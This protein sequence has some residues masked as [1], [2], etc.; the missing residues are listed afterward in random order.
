MLQERVDAV[1]VGLQD[2]ENIA[3]RLIQIDLRDARKAKGAHRPIGVQRDC[4]EDLAQS[5]RGRAPIEFHLP[6]SV[7]RVDEALRKE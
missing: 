5:P 7:L 1:R 2:A 4:A 3:G 6:Q